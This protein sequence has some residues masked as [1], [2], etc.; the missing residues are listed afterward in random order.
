MK[1]IVDLYSKTSEFISQRVNRIKKHVSNEEEE[2]FASLDLILCDG[3]FFFNS[4]III[5][6]SLLQRKFHVQ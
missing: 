6:S 2:S 1:R 5:A 4:E 3:A